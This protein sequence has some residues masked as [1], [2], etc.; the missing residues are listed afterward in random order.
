MSDRSFT[1]VKVTDIHGKKKGKA[2][3]GGRYISSTPMG[4]A[5]KAASQ[6]CRASS[7]KGRCTL[8]VTVQ[9]TTQG[10]GKKE[11]TYKVSRVYDPVVVERAG[12]EIVYK[13]HLEAHAY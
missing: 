13:Y 1:I 4:A 8:I 2:N 9:E 5:K 10:S 7:I 3:L 6:I 12:E 11:Y